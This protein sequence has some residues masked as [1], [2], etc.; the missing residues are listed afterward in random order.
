MWM[1]LSHVCESDRQRWRAVNLTRGLHPNS[2]TWLKQ[3]HDELAVI[4]NIECEQMPT[5][6]QPSMY[7][8]YGLTFMYLKLRY[9]IRPSMCPSVC[10]STCLMLQ[11]QHLRQKCPNAPLSLTTT[12]YFN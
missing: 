4:N 7:I 11:G 12:I 9:P 10:P 8:K 5:P 2:I 1:C 6:S 3:L